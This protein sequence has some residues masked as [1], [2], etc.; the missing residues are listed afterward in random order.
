MF[1]KPLLLVG[2]DEC[3]HGFEDVDFELQGVD[4]LVIH[5]IELKS[6]RKVQLIQVC[7]SA[8]EGGNLLNFLERGR[9][10]YFLCGQ[11]IV[12][13]RFWFHDKIY[14]LATSKL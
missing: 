11:L 5:K 4:I 13:L 8:D 12:E 1:E 6:F 2:E 3:R 9:F 10:L 7:G 14:Y